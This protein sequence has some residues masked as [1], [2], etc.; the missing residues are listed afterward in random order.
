M[1]RFFKKILFSKYIYPIF[2]KTYYLIFRLTGGQGGM[3][4]Q[5]Y[6]RRLNA[7]EFFSL[8]ELE[9]LQNDKLRKLIKEVYENV[10][11]Y[12]KIMDGKG[13]IPS[14]IKTKEDLKLLP[15]LTKQKIRENFNDLL[16]VRY[17]EKKLILVM[18][19]GTTGTPLKFYFTKHEDGVRNAH[20]ERWKKN[21]GVRQF[22]RFMYIGMDER[23][24]NNPDYSGTFTPTG[25]YLM[26]AFGL[27]DD[28]M[29]KHLRNIKRFKPVYLRGYASACYILADFFKR[30]K[31]DYPLKAVLTSSDMIYPFQK[32][33]IEEVFSCK[34]FDHY[35]QV[36]D[37][38]TAN[39]CEY[40]DGYHIN[41]ESC[42]AEILDESYNPVAEGE[43]GIIVG[44]QLEN[45]CT[46]LIRYNIGDMGC[47]TREKCLCGRNHIRIKKLFGR[48]DDW[49]I[50][51]DGKRIGVQINQTM[52]PLYDEILETQFIQK[53]KDTLIV[54][55]VPTDKYRPENEKEFE[56]YIRE[57][58]GN[59]IKI[60]FQKVFEIPKTQNGKHQLIISEISKLTP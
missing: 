37:I 45:Y 39:E 50:T 60:Q 33:V 21:A 54:K 13:L 36:E 4:T 31:V 44:T 16:N 55:F 20:W 58:V 11:Y 8:D 9:V 48:K 12:R 41:M 1:K 51:P 7:S 26:A 24:K 46:P 35:G 15:V 22:D 52:E 30:N 6:L 25:F 59:L 5:R 27:N 2:R 28:L 53:T 43:M 10:P 29:H 56:K 17:K 14:D 49:I 18:T 19:G 32:K 23:A 3:E 57:Q 38:V 34:V 40:H 47:I 42:I